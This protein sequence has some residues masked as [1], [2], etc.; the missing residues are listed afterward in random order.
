M[1]ST[2]T[3]LQ[4]NNVFVV[5]FFAAPHVVVEVDLQPTTSTSGIRGRQKGE[6]NNAKHRG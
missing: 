6:N 3:D 2:Q 5:H 4:H 1:H